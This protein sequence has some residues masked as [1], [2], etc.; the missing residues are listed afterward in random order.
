MEVR[1]GDDGGGGGTSPAAANVY[2]LQAVAMKYD[3]VDCALVE[4]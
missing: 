1:K 4:Y 2:H 3:H